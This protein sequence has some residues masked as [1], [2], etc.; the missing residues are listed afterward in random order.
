MR[1]GLSRARRCHDQ[2]F[3]AWELCDN[4]HLHRALSQ[5]EPL[6]WQ[7]VD[8]LTYTW[9]MPRNRNSWGVLDGPGLRAEECGIGKDGRKSVASAV[10]TFRGGASSTSRAG[11]PHSG[12]ENDLPAIVFFFLEN[13]V[14]GGGFSQW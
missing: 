4:V 12:D 6:S 11:A 2:R 1:P 13:F 5:I 8:A 9:Q 14:A 10:R 7:R 3:A